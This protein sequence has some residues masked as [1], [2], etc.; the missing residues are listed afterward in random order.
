MPSNPNNKK[1]PKKPSKKEK[2]LFKFLLQNYPKKQNFKK[3]NPFITFLLIVLI[4]TALY[5]IFGSNLSEDSLAKREK[6]AVSEL[7]KLYQSQ[8]LSKI[9]VKRGEI[10][11][12][13]VNGK[14]YFAY[15]LPN[16]N[17][18][19][20]ALDNENI[21]TPVFVADTESNIFW[22]NLISSIIPVLIIFAIIAFMMRKAGSGGGLGFGMS[23]AKMFTKQNS[24]TKFTDVAGCKESKEELIE[25]VD[26]LKH[27][28]KYLKLGAKI[29]RGILLVGEPGT[30]KTLLARAVAGEAG[31]P[32]FLI[33]G[34]EF[35]EM[36]VG[37]GAS[38]VRDLFG[39][40]KKLAPAIIFID[41]IDAI[42]K[43]RGP[44]FGG[45][46]D[47]REQTLNQILTEMDGFENETNVIV[48]A[49]TNR[50]DVLDK[51]LLRPGRFDRRV[52]IDKPDLE[53]R[54]EILTV[55]SRSKPLDKKVDLKEIAKKTPGF[56]GAELE[57]VMN[58]AAILTAKSN[59]QVINQ[60]ILLDAVEKVLM[61]PEKK[62]VK[63]IE[64][65]KI[66][67]AYH[68]VGHALVSHIIPDCDPVHKIS[69]VARGMS[70]GSTWYLPNEERRMYS[71]SKF[72]GEICSL[73]GGRV[74]EEIK[75]GKDEI[76]TGASNDL[77]RASG[78]ARRMVT[79][80]GMSSLGPIVFGEKYQGGFAGADF[81]HEKNYSDETALKIDL[82]VTKIIEGAFKK[83]REI[84][85]K[86][87]KVFEKITKQL[88]EKEVLTAQEF[89]A[90]FTRKKV[91]N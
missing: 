19:D 75:F 78:V 83:T 82:E 21:P 40:A 5:Q 18:K 56:A 70:L 35:I 74:A 53:A 20:L 69:I 33:S 28:K 37:V 62:S 57:S 7:V 13:G 65:E 11:A 31:V 59:K 76:T 63:L 46:H 88:L 85:E 12:D 52:I 54:T 72:I 44:G 71:K 29:P 32:F 43:Q 25:V 81:G 67:T 15:K 9:T 89:S 10:I 91:I 58:E 1:T 30:G 22:G 2:E 38:R 60:T 8:Q 23:K 39:K 86:N 66:I 84:I 45:G 48:L 26:F 49:A 16:E 87:I 4:I 17:R 55:H 90:F 42:G 3:R 77:E 80:Y 61:G 73:L 47:E 6:I 27:P 41:E 24:K 64:K 50:P 14:K 68:E 34:S 51:A 36:F 79:E